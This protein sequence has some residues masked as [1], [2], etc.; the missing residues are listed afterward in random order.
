MYIHTQTFEAWQQCM[1]GQ[2][3]DWYD[4]FKLLLDD[5]WYFVGMISL[6]SFFMAGILLSL[7]H[8]YGI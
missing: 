5:S 2:T 8:F 1:R 3:I 6:T 4:S 7:Q